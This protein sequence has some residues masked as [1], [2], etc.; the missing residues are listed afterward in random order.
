MCVL[1]SYA[2]DIMHLSEFVITSHAEGGEQEEDRGRR[3]SP[4]RAEQRGLASR[5]GRTRQDSRP[6]LRHFQVIGLADACVL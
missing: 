5:L 6:A 1:R 4:I 2:L 3:A